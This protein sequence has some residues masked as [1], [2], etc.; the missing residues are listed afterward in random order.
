MARNCKKIL[1]VIP[2]LV[3]EENWIE[4]FNKW[5]Y[6]A[7]DV[8]F[9]TYNSLD[10]HADVEWDLIIVDEAHHLTE[11]CCTIMEL[12]KYH[13]AIL[14]SATIKREIYYRLKDTFY[15]LYR[16][17]IKIRE[18][19]DDEILPDPKAILIPLT[20]DNTHCREEYKKGKSTLLLTERG[21]YNKLSATIDNLKRA[22]MGNKFMEKRWLNQAGMRLKWLSNKK[23]NIVLEI[24][25]VLKDYRTLTFCNSI[26]QTEILGKNAIHSKKKDNTAILQQFNTGKIKHITGVGILDEGV[27]LRNC[28]IGIY[29][30]LNSSLRIVQQRLGRTLRHKNPIIIIPYYVGTR[31]EEIVHKMLEDYN[32]KLVKTIHN[33]EDIKYETK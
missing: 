28:Q 8:V 13:N 21:Y 1:I 26:A 5:D 31:D 11:R 18:A 30:N 16:Y 27:N 24:L 9:S 14:L 22:A 29:A 20:L 10:K 15:N 6:S 4:E 33:I 12:M 25:R 23:T 7:E 2:K 3:L 19:I 32:P 17:V